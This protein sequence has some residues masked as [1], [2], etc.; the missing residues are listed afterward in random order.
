[1]GGVVLVLLGV[2]LQAC[3]ELDAD[4]EGAS[5]GAVSEQSPDAS[6]AGAGGT[7]D[8]PEDGA[9]GETEPTLPPGHPGG[10]EE[11]A[12]IPTLPPGHP[13][14]IGGATGIPC[15]ETSAGGA[16]ATGVIIASADPPAPGGLGLG[17]ACEACASASCTSVFE[18][19]TSNPDCPLMLDCTNACAEPGGCW[20]GCL[21]LYP[22]GVS[23][24]TV[25]LEC[26]AS[27]CPICAV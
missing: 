20:D 3:L 13:G 21:E 8:A 23:D 12:G 11:E 14:G 9:A 1:M 10:V 4:S 27:S 7:G 2:G 17:V 24:L 26:L 15:D 18:A 25:L 16:G 6:G 5:A 22:G 19:C